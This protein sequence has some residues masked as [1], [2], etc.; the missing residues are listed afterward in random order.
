VSK[1]QPVSEAEVDVPTHTQPVDPRK[2][3]SYPQRVHIH[4]RAHWQGMLQKCEDRIATARQKMN[5][6]GNNS[7]NRA[8]FERLFAQMLGARD[9]VADAA[10][11]LPMETGDLYEED[12]HR[13]EEAVAAL[14]R[15]FQRWETQKA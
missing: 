3:P 10:R 4:E 7:P 9:Q 12:K 6:L 13:L 11:R 1:S 5:V 14:D 2:N 15:V 8:A